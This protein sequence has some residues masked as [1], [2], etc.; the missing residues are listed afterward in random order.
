MKRAVVAGCLLALLGLAPGFVFAQGLLPDMSFLP[1]VGGLFKASQNTGCYESKA[2][3]L[4]GPPIVWVGYGRHRKGVSL[5]AET[6]T[7]I[8]TGVLGASQKY[9]IDGVHLEGAVPV[10]LPG[11]PLFFVGGSWFFP[12][13]GTSRADYPIAGP[14]ADSARTWD[15]DTQWW[16]AQAL[17]AQPIYG[18]VMGVGG[19]RF[20]SWMTNFSDP[21]DEVEFPDVPTDEADLTLAHHIPFFGLWLSH[22]FGGGTLNVGAIGFPT[23]MGSIDYKETA[24]TFRID[25]HGNYHSGYFLEFFGDY[26]LNVFGADVG[27]FGRHSHLHGRGSLDTEVLPTG[28]APDNNLDYSMDRKVWM[29]GGKLSVNFN[30]F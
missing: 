18:G 16:T 29:V 13:N 9:P 7:P 4:V 21:T 10:T 22:G 25:N 30:V 20:D 3:S 12:S 27:I 6:D 11:A 5:S 2:P 19:Y 8:T 26:T 14:F 28:I 15:T 1:G 17:F 23:V 24:L